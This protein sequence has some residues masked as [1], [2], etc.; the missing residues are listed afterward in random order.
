MAIKIEFKVDKQREIFDQGLKILEAANFLQRIFERDGSLWSSE[1]S[2]ISIAKNRLGWLELPETMLEA[3][4]HIKSFAQE[5]GYN[6][7]RHVVHLGMGGSSLAPEVLSLTFRNAPGFPEFIVLDSTDPDQINDVT[8]HID[9]SSTIFIVA[10][11]S[12]TT[13]ETDSLARFFYEKFKTIDPLSYREHF[14]AIT[15]R[16]TWLEEYSEKNYS[17]TFLNPSDIG[18]RYSALSY[19][20]IVP[21]AL[22]G[23]DVRMFLERSLDV[24]TSCKSGNVLSSPGVEVGALL[25][26]LALS[27]IDKLTVQTSSSIQSLGN[28]IEQLIAE[29]TGKQGKGILPVVNEQLTTPEFYSAD[30]VFVYIGVRSDAEVEKEEKLQALELQGYPIIKMLIDDIYDLSGVFYTWEVATS[31]A[32]AVLGI[33][34]FDEPNVQESKEN[35]RKILREFELTHQMSFDNTPLF[36]N[37]F[38]IFGNI[39]TQPFGDEIDVIHSLFQQKTA[40]GYLAIM[41]YLPRRRSLEKEFLKLQSAIRDK[42]RI[43]VTFGFGPRYLHSTGQFHK[44]GGSDGLFLQFVHSPQVNLPIPGETYTFADLFRAQAIGD[45]NALKSKGKPI[46]SIQLGKNYED[47]ITQLIREVTSI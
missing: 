46:L 4:D 45:Y 19:F 30:R 38:T 14:V 16:G 34:P 6:R 13:M 15:D 7:Y 40:G 8:T 5:K 28:W 22:M 20:G 35:T 32:A 23:H 31:A 1:P 24:E 11:K 37:K 26:M 17:K 2:H 10:S 43:P 47:E 41:A 29:S 42:L 27:G 25:G 18:G 44:G 21:F 33:D 9:L 36:K 3:V 12:G 39:K